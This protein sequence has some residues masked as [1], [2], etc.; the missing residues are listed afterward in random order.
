MYRYREKKCLKQ[1]REQ[2][3]NGWGAMCW[4]TIG[5]RMFR[6]HISYTHFTDASLVFVHKFTISLQPVMHTHS[7]NKCHYV[8]DNNACLYTHKSNACQCTISNN[9][10]NTIAFLTY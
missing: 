9:I 3:S 5:T 7:N 10:F 4:I 6:M 2:R 1:G 8:H